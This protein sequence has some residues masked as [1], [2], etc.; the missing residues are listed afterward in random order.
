MISEDYTINDQKCFLEFAN[1]KEPVKDGH[2][3]N[4]EKG[5]IIQKRLERY[6]SSRI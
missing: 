6:I 5:I 4:H 3:F 1:G 2:R